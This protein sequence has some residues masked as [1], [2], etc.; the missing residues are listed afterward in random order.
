[1]EFKNGS[2]ILAQTD[3]T[4]GF[5]SKNITSLLEA[6]QRGAAKSFIEVVA[7]Q[8]FIT[9]KIAIPK[10]AKKLVRRG[11]RTTF[12]IKGRSFRISKNQLHNLLLEK[13]EPIYS[14]SANLTEK[15]FSKKYAETISDIIVSDSRGI[16]ED[17]PSRI[18]KI[19]NKKIVRIR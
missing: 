9:S 3:T 13:I 18:L 16:K 19:A 4:V 6:K 8:S 7:T 2:L 11:S 5:L 10:V 15:K 1:L 14:T 12:V 17:I